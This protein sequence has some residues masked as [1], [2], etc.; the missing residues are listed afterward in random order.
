MYRYPYL[1]S[2]EYM[3]AGSLAPASWSEDYAGCFD[4][5]G[6]VSGTSLIGKMTWRGRSR[7]PNGYYYPFDYNII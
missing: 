4:G 6:M 2:K 3:I 1:I 7:A 5:F